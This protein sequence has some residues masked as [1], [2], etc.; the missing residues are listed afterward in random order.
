MKNQKKIKRKSKE[1]QKKIKRKSKEN[2]KK[3]QCK[4]CKLKNFI[5]ILHSSVFQSSAKLQ[6]P[7]RSSSNQ[8]INQ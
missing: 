2:Q 4:K 3:N 6:A 5:S 8:S 7:L 1:N